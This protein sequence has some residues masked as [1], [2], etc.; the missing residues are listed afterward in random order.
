MDAPEGLVWSSS[1]SDPISY[2]QMRADYIPKT[3]GLRGEYFFDGVMEVELTL[4]SPSNRCRLTR[5]SCT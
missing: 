1:L 4:P 5:L 2:L 3:I